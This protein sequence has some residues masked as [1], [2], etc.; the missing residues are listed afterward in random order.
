MNLFYTIFLIKFKF[1]GV[2]QAVNHEIQRQMLIKDNGGTIINET[3]AWD[4]ASKSTVA[5][6]DKEVVQDYRF[7]PEPNLP[8]LHVITEPN[9]HHD[10]FVNAHKLSQQL[11]PLPSEIRETLISNYGLAEETAIILVNEKVLYDFFNGILRENPKRSPKVTANFLINELLTIGNKHKLHLEECGFQNAHIGQLVDM[12]EEKQINLNLAQLILAEMLESPKSPLEIAEEN[13]WKLIRD[14]ERIK[15]YC[16]DVLKS[17][18]GQKMIK[19]YKSG[20]VKVVFAIA[21]EINKKSNNLIDMS[22]CIEIIKKE[23][24]KF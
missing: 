5:M 17:D 14:T 21:G 7:M 6:R 3:R 10:E 13:N 24:K 18:T 22:I 2:A 15:E 4:A 20:K 16:N 19:A 23:L 1:L 12:I 11:P 9:A 8:P